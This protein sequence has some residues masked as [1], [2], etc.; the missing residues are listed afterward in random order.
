MSGQAIKKQLERKPKMNIKNWEQ[1]PFHTT[2]LTAA[3]ELP[4]KLLE[5]DKY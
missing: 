5:K 1:S 2:L 4:E 3:V